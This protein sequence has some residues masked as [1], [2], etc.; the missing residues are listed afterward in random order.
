MLHLVVLRSTGTEM[1]KLLLEHIVETRELVNATDR[2]GGTPLHNCTYI[3]GL[4]H[5]KMLLQA[6]ATPTIKDNDGKTPYAYTRGQDSKELAKYL[7]SQLSPEQ[8]E[9]EKRLPSDW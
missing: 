8:Q 7:W 1:L 4:E 5:A 2:F 9:R 3:K 6:G